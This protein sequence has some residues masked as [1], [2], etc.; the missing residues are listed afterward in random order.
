LQALEIRYHIEAADLI[1]VE[2]DILIEKKLVI[3]KTIKA[4]SGKERRREFRVVAPVIR[5]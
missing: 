3:L 2:E 4:L 5:Q 1:T